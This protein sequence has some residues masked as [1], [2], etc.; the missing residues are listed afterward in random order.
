MRLLTALLLLM[1]SVNSVA[2]PTKILNIRL[3]EEVQQITRLIFELNSPANY[4]VF[5]LNAPHRLV[6]DFKNT[7]LAKDPPNPPMN[8]SVLKNIR[9]A[10]HDNNEL[11]VVLDLKQA[12]NANNF[13]LQPSGDYQYRLIVDIS[14]SN[15]SASS[16]TRTGSQPVPKQSEPKPALKPS[17]FPVAQAEK[18]VEL[19]AITSATIPRPKPQINADLSGKRDIIVA[20]DAGHG[21]VD[22]GAIG[23]LG[24]Y[25]KDIVLAIA[26]SLYTLLSN[27][28]G[29]Q[30][31]MIRQDDTFLKLRDRIDLARQY[32]A[33]LFISIHADAYADNDT[34]KGPSVYMLSQSGA[35]SEAAKWL[36][37]KENAADLLGG[38]SISDKDD[39]LASVLLDLSQTGTLEASAH[40]GAAL[41]NSLS[42]V[43]KLH[44]S[45]VQQAAFMVLRSPDIPSVL[46]ETG[47]IST[48]AEEQKLQDP[49]YRYRIALALSEGIKAYFTKYPPPGTLLARQ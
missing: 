40:V 33:D 12:I 48:P 27:E 30:P 20:I 4:T 47:F 28:E 10:P 17:D 11:R 13:F 49:D 26:R 19:K 18:K 45:K 38:V 43:S 9:S 16:T 42:S 32:Q 35:S 2:E 1:F 15:N 24:A 3:L 5:T 29:F 36:A 37:E 22:P 8:H 41:V 21:G 7:Q 31:V 23:K 25:E 6:I 39:L 14:P 44:H 46:V 34:A